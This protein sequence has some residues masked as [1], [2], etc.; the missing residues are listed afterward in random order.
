MAFIRARAP[1]ERLLARI[2][3]SIL[4]ASSGFIISFWSFSLILSILDGVRQIS[5][6]R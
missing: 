6:A 1:T 2:S 3:A 4:A 5:L